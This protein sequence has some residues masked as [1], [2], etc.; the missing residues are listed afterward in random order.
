MTG[1]FQTG[2]SGVRTHEFGL[3]SWSNNIANINTKGYKANIPEFASMFA[4]RMDSINSSSPVSN[5]MNYGVTKAA[6]SM[7]SRAGS[8]VK[9]A[10]EFD[11][12]ITGDGWF[13]VSNKSGEKNYYTRNG[14]FKR[15][16][17]G[18]L[19]NSD[20][21]YLLGLDR[22]MIKNKTF[23]LSRIA[24]SLK[25]QDITQLKPIKIE[26]DIYIKPSATRFINNSINL[27]SSKNIKALDEAFLPSLYYNKREK[28]F[29][30]D[31]SKFF[32]NLQ[33]GD[34]FS[35]KAYT[36]PIKHLSLEYGKD[37]KTI[38]E[39]Q[40]ALSPHGIAVLNVD[41]RRIILK[42][43]T[44]E[45]IEYGGEISQK[46]GLRED[47]KNRKLTSSSYLYLKRFFENDF[48]TLYNENYESLNVKD[49]DTITIEINKKSQ[50]FTYRS[51][52]Q[53]N[54][55]FNTIQQLVDQIKEKTGLDIFVKNCRLIFE[56]NS[57]KE[58]KVR[59]TSLNDSLISGLSLPEEVDIRAKGG[60]VQ[61]S[62]LKVPTYKSTSEIFDENG[63][64][65][66]VKTDYVL[67][68]L[69]SAHNPKESWLT[70]SAVF[71]LKS[72]NIISKDHTEGKIEY[73]GDNEQPKLYTLNKDLYN[74]VKSFK[75]DFAQNG[76]IKFDP[77]GISDTN[78]STTAHYMNSEVK[79]TNKDGNLEGYNERVIIDPNGEI[80]IKFSNS[81][82]ESIGRV[83]L[84]RFINN[85][86][87]RKVGGNLYETFS[88]SVN[89]EIKAPTA[90]VPHV[91]WDKIT[92]TL[93][94]SSILQN[95]L[96]TSNVEMSTALTELII[97]QRGYSA[98]SKIVSTADELIKEAIN[99]KR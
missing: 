89:G 37:F 29:K 15:D 92:G 76:A 33:E 39:F 47:I 26:E 79:T 7:D 21:M 91:V 30:S 27:N 48:N 88:T 2:V 59:F 23:D 87:L 74:R 5:D 69:R 6:N 16:S 83:G 65:Y 44:D 99:L 10:S 67:R 9:G 20:G 77:S 43:V 86:G 98:N 57:D 58:I 17:E 36:K 84:V 49:G 56:N 85:Q 34:K 32:S 64:K 94:G 18:Y 53:N 63:K 80:K 22:G 70:T 8:I 62:A 46:L 54:G 13:S 19:V 81:M 61:S 50:T 41:E 52:P 73:S 45:K 1:S 42:N 25:R 11:M 40:S 66:L 35:V 78:F 96:E 97:M 51:D 68:H 82:T 93:K 75:I 14:E 3:N 90:G 4:T 55:E 95:R 60:Q 71:D 72:D 38:E 28:L 31:L 12:A 24:A